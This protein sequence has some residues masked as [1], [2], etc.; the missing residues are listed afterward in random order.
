MKKRKSKNKN[1]II[2][3]Y[4]TKN[5]IIH[6]DQLHKICDLMND[7]TL[8]S[9]HYYREINFKEALLLCTEKWVLSHRNI[10]TLESKSGNVYGFLF[11]DYYAPDKKVD[12]T[13]ICIDKSIRNHGLATRLVRFLFEK[14]PGSQFTANYVI[15][16]NWIAM[17]F[18]KSLGFFTPIHTTLLADHSFENDNN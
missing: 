15:N 9:Y 7:Y 11:Y 13:N 1:L 14:Y 2:R 10:I 3:E 12:I 8:D 16:E 18:W 5:H 4:D 17:K 6:Q